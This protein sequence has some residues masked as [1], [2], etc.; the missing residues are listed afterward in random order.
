MLPRHDHPPPHPSMTMYLCCVSAPIKMDISPFLPGPVLGFI[1]CLF[2]LS[3]V[4]LPCPVGLSPRMCSNLS[5]CGLCR[6]PGPLKKL[7]LFYWSKLHVPGSFLCSM[8]LCTRSVFQKETLTLIT[9]S[10]HMFSKLAL[11]IFCHRQ[12]FLFR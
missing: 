2:I 5:C 3:S 9:G 11:Q 1:Q 4:F 10:H 12:S 6:M 7:E 8:G